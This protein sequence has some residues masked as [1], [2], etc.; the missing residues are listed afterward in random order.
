MS[1]PPL[2]RLRGASIGYDRRPVIA[3]VDL[4]V[5]PGEVVA[6]LGPNGSGK[7]TLV[8]GMLGLARD[9][10]RRGAA[11]RSAGGAAAGPVAGG[12]RAPAARQRHRPADHRRRGGRVRPASTAAALA[13]LRPRRPRARGRGH[14]DGRAGR[15]GALLDAPP[16]RW[17]A[18]ARADRPG[19]RGGGRPAGPRRADG[20]GRC[21]EPAGSGRHGRAP[22]RR[23]GDDPLHHPRAGAG[24]APVHAGGRAARRADR[25]TTARCPVR[26]S[27]ATIT[28][29]TPCPR[30]PSWFGT[31]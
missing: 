2:V 31:D 8:R 14:R 22:G 27:T 13:A 10:G 20:R 17:A 28:T 19:P 23:R 15:T 6:L 3:G 16:V 25:R 7:S 4:V 12:V 26:P 11:V 24:G 29:T 1:G 21:G 18:A 9:P 5:E 30:R